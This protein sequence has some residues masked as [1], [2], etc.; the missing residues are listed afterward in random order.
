MAETAWL[1]TWCPASMG[2]APL[3]AR[4]VEFVNDDHAAALGASAGP[5]SYRNGGGVIANPLMRARRGSRC[6]KRVGRRAAMAVG[7][8][9]DIDASDLVGTPGRRKAASDWGFGRTRHGW[10]VRGASRAA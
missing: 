4:V 7:I 8:A 3:T 6:G 5:T 2:S 10:G 1:G 9:D